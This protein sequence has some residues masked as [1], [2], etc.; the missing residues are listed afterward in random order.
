VILA[1]SICYE[2]RVPG[3]RESGKCGPGCRPPAA[4]I[5][6]VGFAARLPAWRRIRSV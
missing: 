2:S 5:M 3:A 1:G 4:D 6:D